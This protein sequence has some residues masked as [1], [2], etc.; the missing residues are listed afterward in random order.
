MKKLAA[1]GGGGGLTRCAPKPIIIK[2]NIRQWLL[3]DNISAS[4]NDL[5]KGSI[6]S[7]LLQ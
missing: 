7:V 1:M 3:N 5:F 2:N 6:D 4:Y